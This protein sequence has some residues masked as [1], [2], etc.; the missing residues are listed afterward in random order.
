[1]M[2]RYA[3]IT[4]HNRVNNAVVGFTRLL[5]LIG[6][7]AAIDTNYLTTGADGTTHEMTAREYGAWLLEGLRDAA[8]TLLRA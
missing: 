8:D 1:M 6:E 2:N 3:R 5:E 4:A 7:D